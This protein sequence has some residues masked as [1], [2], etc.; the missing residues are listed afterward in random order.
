LF[1]LNIAYYL[2]KQGAL[3]AFNKM[4]TEVQQVNVPKLD[5]SQLC[6]R[7]VD[8]PDGGG[9]YLIVGPSGRG[10]SRIIE[11]LVHGKKHLIP[12]AIAFS[13]SEGY[14]AN[15]SRFIPPLFVYDKITPD[16]ITRLETRQVIAINTLANPL[17]TVILDDCMNK[18]RNFS[19]DEFVKLFKIGRHQKVYMLIAMQ[20][21]GDIGQVLKNQCAGV[22]LL[23]N[24]NQDSR[25]R[26]YSD[27]GGIFPNKKI[28][29][30]A[31]DSMTTDYAAL[32]IDLRSQSAD[33]TDKI[34]WFKADDK[35][36]GASWRA[37]S[38]DVYAFNEDRYDPTNTLFQNPPQISTNAVRTSSL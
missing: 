4:A 13:E 3:A 33:W 7:S 38:E 1:D 5:V 19:E 10:K 20:A 31:M 22:F 6:P 27:F 25:S 26:L 17:I 37:C 11:T 8:D 23:R 34:K 2:N 15:Y 21:V 9:I 32:F 36:V 29:E 12:L 16:W 14:N 18:R 35:L 30:N 24:E 28:F